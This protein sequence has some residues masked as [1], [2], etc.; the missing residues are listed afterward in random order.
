MDAE[1][2]EWMWLLRR[3][4][5]RTAHVHEHFAFGSLLFLFHAVHI[6]T[7][8][9]MFWLLSGKPAGRQE[10]FI[11]MLSSHYCKDY[12]ECYIPPLPF[13]GSNYFSTLSF[14]KPEQRKPFDLSSLAAPFG[15][16][17]M[18]E[19]MLATVS[20]F[21]T[22]IIVRLSGKWN[23]VKI[24][25]SVLSGL[26]GQSFNA[27]RGIQYELCYSLWLLSVGF[28][29][30]GYTNVLQSILVVPRIQHTSLT[31]TFQAM[32]LENFTF[33]AEEFTYLKTAAIQ[34]TKEEKILAERVVE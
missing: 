16:D 19:L 31:F 5:F 33:E 7:F 18:A 13:A 26:V 9:T 21:F 32:L 10:G 11:G 8:D 27:S 3:Y 2:Q 30:M 22:L 4:S 17:Y 14:S 25:L 6:F 15:L 20:S 29:S 34:I 1:W 12:H 28:L 24:A 23:I